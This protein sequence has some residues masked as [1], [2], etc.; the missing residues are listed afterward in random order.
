MRLAATNYL[1]EITRVSRGLSMY[2]ALMV[3]TIQ[4]ARKHGISWERIGEA[5]GVSRQAATQ[6]YAKHMEAAPPLKTGPRKR[7]VWDDDA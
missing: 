3:E 1:E 7:D 2:D 4:Q 5:L 6:R